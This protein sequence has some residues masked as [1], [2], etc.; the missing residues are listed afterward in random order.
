M[1]ILNNKFCYLF[2]GF[3]IG[4]IGCLSYKIILM[5]RYGKISITRWDN[6]PSYVTII[7]DSIRF[8]GKQSC[9]IALEYGEYTIEIENQVR[10]IRIWKNNRGNV[11]IFVNQDGSVKVDCDSNSDLR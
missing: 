2:A 7:G 6:R 3:S 9:P 5:D 8:D 11:Q 10:S 1:K 4:V